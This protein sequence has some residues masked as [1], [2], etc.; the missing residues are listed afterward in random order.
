MKRP[1]RRTV[2]T[3]LGVVMVVN[4]A[5]NVA[6][7]F[8]MKPVVV[9]LAG[10]PDGLTKTE[11]AAINDRGPTHPLTRVAFQSLGGMSLAGLVLKSEVDGET[12]YRLN[13]DNDGAAHIIEALAHHSD[14]ATSEGSE[15][16]AGSEVTEDAAA[17]LVA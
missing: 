1:S 12:V 7:G 9:A 3:V 11:I 13:P 10:A 8:A 15:V 2:L 17:A 16:T 4:T 14:D 5:V 6:R